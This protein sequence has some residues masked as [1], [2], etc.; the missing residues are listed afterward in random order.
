MAIVGIPGHAKSV[1]NDHAMRENSMLTVEDV[2]KSFSG[3]PVLRGVGFDARD[4]E[5]TAFLGLNGAGKSTLVKIIAGAMDHW[6]GNMRID[7]RNYHPQSVTEAMSAGV[8]VVHQQRT[9]ISQFTVAQ[10]I[11]LGDEPNRVGFVDEHRAS[12]GAGKLLDQLGIPL[13]PDAIVGTL[14]AGQQQLVDIARA[15][16]REAEVLILDEPTAALTQYEVEKLFALLDRLRGRGLCII[17]VSHRLNEVFE[18]CDRILILRDGEVAACESTASVTEQDVVNLMIGET[19]GDTLSE[20]DLFRQSDASLESESVE[21]HD[22]EDEKP[23]L[24]LT[25][26][27]RTERSNLEVGQLHLYSG[28]V[29]GLAGQVGAGCTSILEYIAGVHNELD[30]DLAVRGRYVHWRS[31]A[32]AIAERICLVP[33][34]RAVKAIASDLSVRANVSLPALSAFTRVGWVRRGVE[35]ARVSAVCRQFSVVM[36]GVDESISALSGGNQQKTVFA[37]WLLAVQD[38]MPQGFAGTVFLL[39][40]PTEG[41][42]V[43]TRPEIAAAVR[44]FTTRGAGVMIASTDSDELLGLCDRIYVMVSGQLVGEFRTEDLTRERLSALTMAA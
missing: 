23:L 25:R 19:G 39:D 9:L 32:D 6:H 28:E 35:K 20:A 2:R 21:R 33:E 42:D 15:I 3:T 31:P 38:A 11:Y 26:R 41:V 34:N 27:V 30:F 16:N 8:S 13:D 7:G 37:R 5:V 36:S 44:D 22:S 40:E 1:I 18:L 24:Q 14:G 4:G 29:V 17:F 12:R 43:K 10:N